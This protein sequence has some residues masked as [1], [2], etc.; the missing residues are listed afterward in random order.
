MLEHIILILFFFMWYMLLFV[1]VLFIISGFD[2]LLIDFAYWFYYLFRRRAKKIHHY[3]P[4]TYQQLAETPE[5]YIAIM[6]PCWHEDNIINVMLENNCAHIDYQ[7]YHFFVGVY[8]NDPATIASVQAAAKLYP[9]VHC[10]IGP[11]PGPTNKASNLNA[12][13]AYILDYEK[14][15]GIQHAIFVLH[16]S[17]DIIHPL[18]L[19]LYNYLMPRKDMI[20]IP[21]FP[22]E[23][24]H[25]QW[26]HWVYNDE[27]AEAHT[28]DIIIR[29][30]FKGL[31]PSAGVGTAFTREAL[32]KLTEDNQATHVPFAANTLTEDYNTALHLKAIGMKQIFLT[33]KVKRT[34]WCKKYG[35]FGPYVK[36]LRYEYIATREL[37]PTQY[38]KA[39]RQKARW[40]LGI[41]IQ[42]WLNSGWNYDWRTVLTLV[43]DRKATITHLVNIL[44]YLVFG[45]WVIYYFWS[46]FRPAYPTLSDQFYHH[47]WAWI[48]ILVCTLMMINRLIQRMVATYRIYGR[49]A[50]FFSLFR[51]FYCNILNLHALLRA[52]RQFFIASTKNKQTN[53]DKTDHQYP[54]AHALVPYTIRL[55]DLLIKEKK[56]SPKILADLIEEQ[57]QT[58]EQLGSLLRKKAYITEQ[59]LEK[60]LATQYHLNIIAPNDFHCLSRDALPP[61]ASKQ[62]EWLLENQCYP[63]AFD[64]PS[65]TLTLAIRDPSNEPFIVDVSHRLKPLKLAFVLLSSAPE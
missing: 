17:E 23:V 11:D 38:T 64:K 55:G 50:S 49:L 60:I 59:D 54:G 21:V 3:P 16:D 58:G 13:Y 40:I 42:E 44:G 8:P 6:T 22:L 41:A 47:P 14:Q 62:Y 65:G 37:F 63:F 4:L 5:K 25:W 43:H 57:Q 27:F 61:I 9:Q 53:W 33:Q 18:S 51:V 31:V 15:A 46:A 36:R 29:E 32:A 52:Y 45:F 20:Q 2:D 1:S 26:T 39:V 10:I 35:L 34:I 19:K 12:I 7:H 56:I 48:L 24:S 30:L 28:K